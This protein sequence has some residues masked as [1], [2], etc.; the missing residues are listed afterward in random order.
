[1]DNRADNGFD[2][3]ENYRNSQ[4]GYAPRGSA[5]EGAGAYSKDGAS[6]SRSPYDSS[7]SYSDEAWRQRDNQV[8]QER[9]RRSQARNN[10]GYHVDSS[11]AGVSA[12][13]GRRV[14]S[15]AQNRSSGTGQTAQMR[16]PVGDATSAA[17][18]EA[19][20]R[21]QAL[22]NRSAARKSST[23][24]RPSRSADAGAH[25]VGT[26]ANRPDTG[27]QV[28]QNRAS[29]SPQPKKNR[30]HPAVIVLIVVFAI[31]LIGGGAAFAYVNFIAGNLHRGVDDDLKSAL[32]HTDMANEPFYMLLL[33]TDKS[34]EREEYDELDG[35]YRTD[36]MMLARIDPVNSKATL[37]SIPRDTLVNLGENGGWQKVN[38]A[39]AFGGPALAVK[40]V[41]DLAG[42]DISHYAEIDFDGFAAMVDALGGIEVDVPVDIDDWEAG[43][44]LSAGLQT[45]DGEQ[46][47]ILCRTRN[48]YA[49]TSAAPDLM[50]A[51]NQRL[52][53][54]AIAHKLLSSD[55]V[56]IA[57]TIGSVSEYVTTDLEVNDIIGIAQTMQ[58]LN[59]EED[60][61]TCSFPTESAYIINGL[62]YPDA[63]SVQP[64]GTAD[65][66]VEEGYYLIPDDESW[67]T[68]QKRLVNG[69]SPMEGS[70]I[71]EKTG[72][73][74]ATAGSGIEDVSDK[75]CWI[76]VKNGTNREGLAKRAMGLLN[77]AGFEN[78]TIGDI[79]D[80][81][82]F[83]YPNTL[84][85]YDNAGR[86][87][88]AEIIVKA[89]G[90]GKAQKNDGSYLV[91]NDFL[92]IIGDDWESNGSDGA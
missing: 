41:S 89:L 72:T 76:T 4:Y 61:Y 45:L 9:T 20:A 55:V 37:I 49:E 26:H 81:A 24:S 73:V 78:I 92:V 7:S 74:L 77:A 82:G 65:A 18:P 91:E 34:A 71:D 23:A 64:I 10:A 75:N 67:A 57:K 47:L 83:A 87:K 11:R 43:G 46:A 8:N 50:R 66:A 44:S 13:N 2:D 5:S 3:I 40:A 39:Y 30:K 42:V 88:E 15:T 14:T 29:A 19:A 59:T 79:N 17:D 69:Q 70:I 63:Y 53:L 16:R 56:T 27:R 86:A 84:V 52:V 12:R 32:V 51:A 58:G 48:T 80:A 68:M 31:A 38:S 33:G 90:Q 85:I 36:S 35:I 1:M 6:Y 25:Q 28:A 60:L 21:R 62:V 22:R 54:S